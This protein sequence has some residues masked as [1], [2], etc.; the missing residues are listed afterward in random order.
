MTKEEIAQAILTMLS[1]R[2]MTAE[3]I[4]Q[5]FGL[6]ARKIAP[7]LAGMEARKQ[8]EKV[9]TDYSKKKN[10]VTLWGIFKEGRVFALKRSL[11]RHPPEYYSRIVEIVSRG[12]R[13][14][15]DIA[16]ELNY[17]VK[18]VSNM[19]NQLER[20]GRIIRNG[21]RATTKRGPV[22]VWGSNPQAGQKEKLDAVKTRAPVIRQP[23]YRSLTAALLGDPPIGASAYDARLS[24]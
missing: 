9:R 11:V 24:A 19:L 4:G 2:D 7:T 18:V 13:T 8:I 22:V 5:S 23:V 12:G 1:N 3:D 15:A 6:S 14:T 16:A 20:T 17:D 21:F 10:G